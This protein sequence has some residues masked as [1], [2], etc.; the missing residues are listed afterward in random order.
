M[1]VLTSNTR[2]LFFRYLLPSLF[3][4]L[5]TTIYC[6]VDNIAI[7]QSEGT[8][9]V[10][11]VAVITPIWG[12]TGTL[13]LLCSIGGSVPMGVAKG[14]GN[15][16]K[17]NAY[18]TASIITMGTITL[19]CWLAFLL[20]HTQ[21]FTLFGADET[22][23]P[24]VL[25][26]GKLIVYF[27]PLFLLN[28][29]LCTYLRNDKA[30]A[31]AM[32]ATLCGGCF[33]IFGDWLFVFPLGMGMR[34]AAIATVLGA[35]VQ[36]LILISHFFTKKCTLRFVMPHNLFKGIRKTLAG[37]ISA[38]V[39]EV[40]LVLITILM[41]NQIMKYGGTTEL[42]VYGVI[43]TTS[44]L[45]VAMFSGVGQALQ[46]LASENFGAGEKVRVKSF[47]RLALMASGTL[48]ILFTCMGV[49]F[50]T[51]ILSVF[52]DIT[53][54][55]QAVAPGIFRI[56]FL[57]FIPAS[58]AVLIIYFLQSCLKNK[59][60]ATIS[61]L[62]SFLVTGAM[63]LILPLVW[64]ITGLWWATPI[65]DTIVACIAIVYAVKVSRK[66][67]CVNGQANTEKGV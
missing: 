45:L 17:G 12:V 27:F 48:G 14:A 62:R 51:Q 41:N 22:L 49:L 11:A 46:P 1:N 33:N 32:A 52:I 29:F 6:F 37:G 64:G 43:V 56:Y 2:R 26:Y 36:F 47:L 8:L 18:F 35:A 66:E 24:K 5:A 16:E 67:L 39:L 9:G 65:A 3:A 28:P 61:L 63:I 60:A 44:G 13:A 23:M 40:G 30:P 58:I 59:A 38:G 10:A 4:A 21:I 54:E 42:A 34:G 53:P 50:P 19:I 31:R 15:E 7:G 55:L 57:T 25:E 20:L